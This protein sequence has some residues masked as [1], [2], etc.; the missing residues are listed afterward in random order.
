MNHTFYPM[1]LA[2]GFWPWPFHYGAFWLLGSGFCL[3]AAADPQIPKKCTALIMESPPSEAWSV[4]PAV[5][6]F[7]ILLTTTAAL[8][9]G[10]Q[11]LER[12]SCLNVCVCVVQRKT[13]Q[14]T[15]GHSWRHAGGPGPC[16]C[17]PILTLAWGPHWTRRRIRD[18]GVLLG[19]YGV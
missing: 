6:G 4:S 9:P 18:Q 15:S 5:T 7:H 12:C 16:P 10:A 1:V 2:S 14:G 19:S 17:P 13:L 8:G 3:S 11:G